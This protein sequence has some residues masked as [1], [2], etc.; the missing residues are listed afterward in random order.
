[1]HL[2]FLAFLALLAR[3]ASAQGEAFRLSPL[4]SGTGISGWLLE[5]VVGI[6]VAAIAVLYRDNSKKQEL[7]VALTRETVNAV[8]AAT[9]SIDA[10]TRAIEHF[11][12]Q[13]IEK[14]PS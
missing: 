8:N 14:H 10:N 5:T 2:P 11:T 9:R 13:A 12:K 4:P 6:A 1:M 3:S 7:I